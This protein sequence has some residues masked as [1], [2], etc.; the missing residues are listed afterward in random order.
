MLTRPRARP[1]PLAPVSCLYR[2]LLHLF[3]VY[4]CS[5]SYILCCLLSPALAGYARTLQQTCRRPA[6]CPD[7]RSRHDTH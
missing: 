2:L 6:A 5:F 4:C 3:P 7:I 1:A